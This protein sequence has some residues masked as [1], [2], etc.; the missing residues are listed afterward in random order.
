MKKRL[1]GLLI[2]V[3]V[4]LVGVLVGK[5]QNTD[6]IS[7]KQLSAMLPAKNFTLINVHTPYEG[8]IE[9]TD[10]FIDF[11]QI[12][13]NSGS[14]PKDKNTP[15]ILYCKTGR[16]STEALET[17][18]K[19]GYTNVKH[20]SGGM[21]A[22]KNSGEKLLDLSSLESD[23]LPKDGIELPVSWKDLG[24][25][26][27]KLGVIDLE[28]FKK[29][30]KLTPQQEN[31]LTKNT[32]ENIRI[33]GTNSQF[34]V[35]ML[36]AL[37]LAQKSTVYEE[38]PMGKEYKDKA[39]NFAS[40]GGWSLAR[41]DAMGYL[42]RFELI[43]LTPEQQKKVG[44]IA[45]NVYRPCCGN[46]TWFPDCNHGMA[47]LAI[48]ELLV[49]NNVDEQTIYKKLLGFNSFWFAD[50]YLYVATYF[51]RQG[52][53]WSDVDAK[54]ILGKEYSSAQGAQA[55]TKKVGQLPNRPTQGGSCGT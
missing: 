37:G 18:K 27:I 12:V 43:K 39:G 11:D 8:E 52:T 29:A 20:L 45:Q 4:V 42:N 25:Q 41:G 53:A 44:E 46:S 28:K 15:I 40:T 13:A 50:S 48:I 22:W 32:E 26:L 9:K 54:A 51:A 1:T 31:I 33:D 21:D 38:G 14:L 6:T 49:A 3:I 17:I 47:A 34:I 35:D 7:A 30:V 24:P 16:M 19:L 5:N 10:T 2:I 23:V 36:W 55:I